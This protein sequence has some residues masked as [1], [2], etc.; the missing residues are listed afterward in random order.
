VIILFTLVAARL[1]G[2]FIGAP[3][4]SRRSIPSRIKIMIVFLLAGVLLP[5]AEV[6]ELPVDAVAV[7]GAMVGE[8]SIGMAI[9]FLARLLVS[10]FQLA[11]SMIAFQMGFALARS[12][13]PETGASSPVMGS[14]YLNLATLLFLLLDGHHFLIQAVAASFETFPVAAPIAYGDLTEAV[15]FSAST[16][17]ELG[18]RIAGPVTGLMLLTNA[19]IGFINRVVP[20]LSIFNIGFP[21]TVMGGLLAVMLSIPEVG[22]FFMRAYAGFEDQVMALI[23]A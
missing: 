20:Q 1:A 15:F 9:G 17:Y 6:P 19:T 12:F 11:G 23:G 21:M 14:L 13:D 18:V 16:M 4:F 2:L 10:A 22:S 8:L 7:A 5:A 3:L